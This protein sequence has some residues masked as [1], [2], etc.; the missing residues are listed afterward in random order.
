M[1]RPHALSWVRE[2]AAKR[3]QRMIVSLHARCFHSLGHSCTETLVAS[4]HLW[5]F[6]HPPPRAPLAGPTCPACQSKCAVLREFEWVK[7]HMCGLCGSG[8]PAGPTRCAWF[9]R[10]VQR[11]CNMRL[12]ILCPAWAAVCS[13]V[14][15]WPLSNPST[16]HPLLP[17]ACTDTHRHMQRRRACLR[18]DWT[19]ETC[20]IAQGVVGAFRACFHGVTGAWGC[21]LQ[22]T[23]P[24]PT[25]RPNAHARRRHGPRLHAAGR[26]VSGGPKA[27]MS[28]LHA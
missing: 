23:Q 16:R 28:T 17:D 2:V 25:A 3:A 10:V 1:H 14:Q 5:A 18:A 7:W 20:M 6:Y 4:R 26:H 12:L 8:G 11:K 27:S 9:E 19:G 24:P 22:H 21:G 15:C 13:T